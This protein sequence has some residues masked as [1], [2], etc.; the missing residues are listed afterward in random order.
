VP[1]SRPM[2]IHFTR[3]NLAEPD[4]RKD[5]RK[6]LLAGQVP[7]QGA[8]ST[9]DEL[10]QAYELLQERFDNLSHTARQVGALAAL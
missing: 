3:S 8:V 9:I 1:Q 6:I 7:E 5:L 4:V 10:L 2:N